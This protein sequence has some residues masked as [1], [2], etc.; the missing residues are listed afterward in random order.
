[1][2]SLDYT[3]KEKEFTDF[4]NSQSANLR[5]TVEFFAKL[6]RM[7]VSDFEGCAVSG[8]IK[9]R[10]ECLNKFTRKYRA[11][12][13]Q[14]NTEYTI[15]NY[16]TDLIGLRVVCLYED[17][18]PRVVAALQ[19]YFS[20]IEATDKISPLKSSP[21]VLGYQAYHMDME[22]N[23]LRKTLS[24]YQEYAHLRFEV[25]IRTLIQD[26]WSQID[27]KIKYKKD[28]PSDLKRRINL[29]S[30]LF[31][32]ADREFLDIR[33]KSKDFI[34][35]VKVT[36][37]VQVSSPLALHP[38]PLTT[39][40]LSQFLANTFPSH[41]TKAFFVEQMAAEILRCAAL[42]SSV[43]VQCFADHQS[44]V[45]MYESDQKLV[46]KPLTFLRHILYLA[47]RKT[48]Q[49]LLFEKQRAS[50]DRWIQHKT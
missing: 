6:I 50:F 26:A 10:L 18:I 12:L 30:G 31:E 32:I 20:Q 45:Q 28:L 44:Q 15:K 1:M 25:Q 23:P 47:D 27:H 39:I 43:L 22:L 5:E 2:P 41:I 49:T 14:S 4:Y 37:D 36:A 33:E 48:F 24:E 3:T 21:D 7:A 8:R 46:F 19:D 13:E 38:H 42:P 29:L 34:E 17:E 9:T 40:E 11:K 16:I 35:S